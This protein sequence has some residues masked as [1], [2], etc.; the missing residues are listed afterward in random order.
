KDRDGKDMITCRWV[1]LACERF[2]D[3]LKNGKK[4]GLEFDIDAANKIIDFY[5]FCRHF[6]GEWEGNSIE[7]EPWQKFIDSNLFGWKYTDTGYRRF[8][9]AYITVARKNGKTTMIAPVGLY[10]LYADDEPGAEVYCLDPSTRILK[11]DLTWQ[12]LNDIQIGDKLIGIDE[13]PETKKKYR[14]LRISRVLNK[15]TVT[16]ES[17]KILFADGRSVIC[18]ADHPWLCRSFRDYGWKKTRE[19][20]PGYKLNSFGHPWEKDNSRDAGY[21]AGFFDGEGYLHSPDKPRA[22]HRIGFAQNPGAVM[23]DVVKMLNDKGFVFT[24]PRPMNKN[25]NCQVS[26]LTGLSNCL[27]FLGQMRPT[28]LLQEHHRLWV[29]KALNRTTGHIEVVSVEPLGM[30]TLIDIETETKTFFAEGFTSHNSAA[31]DRDQAREIFDAAKTMVE[32]DE[33]L[34]VAIK[35]FARNMHV[36]KTRSKFEPLSA[37]EKK[38]HGKNIHAALC[39]EVHVWPKHTLWWVLRTGMGS[40][41]QPMQIAITTAGTDQASICYQIH[42][43]ARKVLT[44]FKG[45]KFVDDSFFGIIYTLDRKSDWPALKTK[46]EYNQE[47]IGIQEDD[48]E[49][50]SVWL[51][52]N[53][54]LGVSVYLKDMRDE[55]RT[56]KQMPASLNSFLNLRMNIWVQQVNRWID[57][58]LWDQNHTSEVYIMEQ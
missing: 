20:R 33:Y 14:K 5:Q 45:G 28:R 16:R 26:D 47:G 53:P 41:R 30:R 23:N 38:Q 13:H 19:I 1:R 55:A 15:R 49:D 37:D 4:R 25:S 22:A 57:I 6:K 17:F 24:A 32:I 48:W 46:A 34:S 42:D 35:T 52:P 51:K 44:G 9:V 36:E 18:S 50:E 40:R 27:R 8:K 7:L 12:A 2:V 43:L 39:D 58:N 29:G 21:L 3:D 56:A 31:V 11:Y 54:N 10:L